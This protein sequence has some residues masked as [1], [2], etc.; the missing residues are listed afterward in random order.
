MAISPFNKN[1]PETDKAIQ[2]LNHQA[3]TANSNKRAK[4]N[5]QGGANNKQ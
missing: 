4:N 1:I 3:N 2:T 5:T